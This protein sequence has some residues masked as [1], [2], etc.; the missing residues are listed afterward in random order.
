MLFRSIFGSSQ[1]MGAFTEIMTAGWHGSGSRLYM[2]CA[3]EYY[4][5]YMAAHEY[6]HILQYSIISRDINFKAIRAGDIEDAYNSAVKEMYDELNRIIKRRG[7]DGDAV[8]LL[9]NYA[10]GELK[11]GIYTDAFAEAFAN[12]ECG[13]PNIW[14][15]AMRDY[16]HGKGIL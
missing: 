8:L 3:K 7:Y 13:A 10:T 16:L 2:P 4:D 1:T 6:G 15:D 5:K 11:K 14:G 9:S 12:M